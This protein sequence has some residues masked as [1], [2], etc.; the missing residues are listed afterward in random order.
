MRFGIRAVLGERDRLVYF[1]FDPRLDGIHVFV[2]EDVA[3]AQVG[4]EG[5]QRIAALPHRQL[6]VGAIERR[7]VFRV[8]AP[9]VRL[10]L[11]ERS[12]GRP[13]HVPNAP[14]VSNQEF[15]NTAAAIAGVTPRSVTRGRLGLSIAGLFI[16]GAK[17][18]I[19]MLYEFEEDF[20]VDHSL[21]ASTFGNHATPL[22]ESLRVTIE[23][24]QQQ[25]NRHS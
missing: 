15:L 23:W 2:V 1:L 11:D 4:G 13:W 10:A 8:A 24:F 19:E 16:P 6:F 7:I 3:V 22:E 20:V 18:T 14:T 9:P 12:V 5:R 17:E 21:Y 25:L